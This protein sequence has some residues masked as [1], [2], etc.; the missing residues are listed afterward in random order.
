M[1]QQFTCTRGHR[2]GRAPDASG[3]NLCPVC[4]AAPGSPS[5]AE[6][7]SVAAGADSPTTTRHALVPGYEL[8][9]QAGIGDVAIVFKARDLKQGRVVAVKFL[10]CDEEAAATAPQRFRREVH[11]LANLSHPNVVTAYESGV[12]DGVPYLVIEHLSGGTLSKKVNGSPLPPR[13]AA[14]LLETMARA[15]HY[16]H[17]RGFVHRNLKPQ[18]ILF[19]ADD[20]PKLIDFGLALVTDRDKDPAGEEGAIVGTPLYMAPEQAEGRMKDIGPATDVYG[21]GAVLYEC[22]TGR[23]P[24]QGPTVMETLQRVGAWEPV[25]PR[26][27]NRQADAEIE[28]VCLRCL[29]KAPRDRY[30]SAL[31]LAE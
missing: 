5:D 4:G 9:G 26:S 7:L 17:G 30:A 23:P 28:G 19:A 1:D 24:F 11:C 3:P 18:N 16:V 6:W 27:L 15:V 13:E 14:Q 31:D 21:L 20:K 29:Q 25:P 10:R 22:L 2:W 8:L 12:A